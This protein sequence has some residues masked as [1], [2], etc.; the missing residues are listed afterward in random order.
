M[1]DRPSPLPNRVAP[2]GEILA[3]PER[4][5]MMGNR[6]GRLH[7][8]DFSLARA[9]ATRRWISCR[10]CFKGRRRQVMGAGYTELFFLDEAVALAAGHRPCFECRRRAARAF[11]EAW[12]RAFALP[13]PPRA[14]AMD[15]V[16]A[17]QRRAPPAPV[18][19]GELPPGALFR[20]D[21]ADWLAAEGRARR[22]SWSG[23][24]PA[25][26]PPP[27]PAQALTPPAIRAVLAAGYRP[28]LHPSA[29]A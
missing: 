26:A 1:T 25:E 18:D 29:T 5:G 16:L 24:G 6:G 27:G 12:A 13:D 20:T 7:A 4:G 2:W 10:L 17:P 15:A 28:D 3:R 14:D 11:A 21:T 22:W 8:P 19:P 23:Y 9:S